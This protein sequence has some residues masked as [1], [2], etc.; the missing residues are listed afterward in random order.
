MTL[1]CPVN[2]QG[3]PLALPNQHFV[4]FRDQI[5]FEVSVDNL[6]KKK[7]KGIVIEV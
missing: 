3:V 1:N 7:A 6:G 2:Q 4:L 5:E